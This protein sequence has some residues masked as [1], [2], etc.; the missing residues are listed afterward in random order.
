MER[1]KGS[2]AT[3]DEI[4]GIVRYAG[5]AACSAALVFSLVTPPTYKRELSFAAFCQR[6]ESAPVDLHMGRGIPDSELYMNGKGK[7]DLDKLEIVQ[8]GYFDFMRA[9]Y[10]DTVFNGMPYS[11][12][13]LMP[14]IKS[15]STEYGVN[16]HTIELIIRS[17]SFGCRYAVGKGG[18]Y[19]LMQIDPRS[20]GNEIG[21]NYAHIFEPE[22]NIEIGTAIFKGCLT[23]F[24]GDYKKALEAYNAG[25]R[26]A[27]TG[28]VPKDT[29]EYTSTILKTQGKLDAPIAIRQ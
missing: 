28:R 22:V 14:T 8:K 24:N 19:G 5:F 21:A 4:R 9:H 18:E 25:S 7:W 29:L 17:E 6:K 27:G 13:K 10:Q 16:P 23:A 3:C 20:Y 26:A 1:Q 11:I 15:I 2:N 12:I